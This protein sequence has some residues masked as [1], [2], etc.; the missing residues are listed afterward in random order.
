MRYTEV[1]SCGQSPRLEMIISPKWNFGQEEDK[2]R[3]REMNCAMMTC[4]F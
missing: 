1:E 2:E 4:F 3:E